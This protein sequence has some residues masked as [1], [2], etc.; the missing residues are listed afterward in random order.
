MCVF[1]INIFNTETIKEVFLC[2][3]AF[4]LPDF[5]DLFVEIQYDFFY[6]IGLL[7]KS[8]FILNIDKLYQFIY[9]IFA[10]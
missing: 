8:S 6:K 2:E 1:S 10:C 7:F 4:I 9:F 5:T 3:L